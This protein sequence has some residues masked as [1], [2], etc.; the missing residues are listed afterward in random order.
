MFISLL[1]TCIHDFSNWHA[2]FV[3]LSITFCS[4]CGMEWDTVC[5]PTDHPFLA[6]L[7]PGAQEPVHLTPILILSSLGS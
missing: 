1:S 4:H 5:K 6:F 7:S 3:F 2:L